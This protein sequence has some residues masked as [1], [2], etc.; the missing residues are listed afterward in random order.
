[1]FEC[2]FK[3]KKLKWCYLKFFLGASLKEATLFINSLLNSLNVGLACTFQR[4]HKFTQLRTDTLFA[5]RSTITIFF[6]MKAK[7]KEMLTLQF[8]TYISFRRKIIMLH[9]FRY[10]ARMYVHLF[11]GSIGGVRNGRFKQ[12]ARGHF[13]AI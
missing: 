3:Q 7:R 2:K 1:M 9:T 4:W 12:V 11:S 10:S 5:L 13:G 6:I 8:H